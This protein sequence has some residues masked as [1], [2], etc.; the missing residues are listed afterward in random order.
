MENIIFIKKYET[1]EMTATSRAGVDDTVSRTY[2]LFPSTCFG[3][4][5]PDSMRSCNLNLTEDN[6]VTAYPGH[7]LVY[8]RD[9]RNVAPADSQG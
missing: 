2:V 7:I 4:S 9:D 8:L 6:V 5:S 3:R 1:V